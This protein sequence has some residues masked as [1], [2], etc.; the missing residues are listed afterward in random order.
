MSSF[1]SDG[2]ESR[3]KRRSLQKST[4]GKLSRYS[5]NKA[6]LNRKQAKGNRKKPHPPSSPPPE[7]TSMSKQNTHKKYNEPESSNNYQLHQDSFVH[8]G[9]LT[10][11]TRYGTSHSRFFVIFAA[12][13]TRLQWFDSYAS[14]LKTKGK[15]PRNSMEILK[16]TEL[17]KSCFSVL[18]LKKKVRLKAP[19]VASQRAWVAAFDSAINFV[20]ENEEISLQRALSEDSSSNELQSNDSQSVYDAEVLTREE[21][22][23]LGHEVF[24]RDITFDL[25][26]TTDTVTSTISRQ[27]S[28]E[29]GKSMLM[30]ALSIDCDSDSLDCN[31]DSSEEEDQLCSNDRPE[32]LKLT[33]KQNHTASGHRWNASN[34]GVD[35]LT[36]LSSARNV[37]ELNR[38]FEYAINAVK[39]SDMQT[40]IVSDQVVYSDKSVRLR[41]ILSSKALIRIKSI[42][43]AKKTW[44]KG[45]SE[46]YHLLVGLLQREGMLRNFASDLADSD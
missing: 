5:I 46:R 41:Q 40:K 1:V 15:N 33:Q 8:F 42:H 38:A 12:D 9:T 6:N 29:L 7:R 37:E 26:S 14:F 36:Q 18:S 27:R 20:R 19:S 31:S 13:P 16:Y 32:G 30:K 45:T 43:I 24:D 3:S 35:V 28:V 10:K 39:A 34:V 4:R 11:W 2:D 44:N 17:P 21:S 22:I 23:E 25:D